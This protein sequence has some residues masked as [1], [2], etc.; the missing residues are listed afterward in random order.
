MRGVISIMRFLIRGSS[1]ELSSATISILGLNF[2]RKMSIISEGRRSNTDF[3]PITFDNRSS[4]ARFLAS[5][6]DC[7]SV[8]FLSFF[9]RSADISTQL[10]GHEDI[11]SLDEHC[12][13]AAYE[14]L[15]ERVID[16]DQSRMW[17]GAVEY[18]IKPISLS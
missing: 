8:C 16:L 14:E 6:L 12:A 18:H 1:R 15:P 10:R 9:F 2:L 17:R 7:F 5:C 13:L 3:S 4:I 11:L